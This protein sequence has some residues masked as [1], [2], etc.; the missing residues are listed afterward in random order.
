M[1]RLFRG[2]V[3]EGIMALTLIPDTYT[4]IL[5]SSSGN[6]GS[7]IQDDLERMQISVVQ[8]IPVPAFRVSELL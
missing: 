7:G 6:T 5:M 2:T 8:A 4:I 3:T 1:K